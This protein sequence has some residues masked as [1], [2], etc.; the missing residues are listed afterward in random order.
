MQL[1]KGSWKSMTLST[2][3]ILAHE[4]DPAFALRAG[5]ILDAV[6]KHKPERILDAGCGRGFYI[7]MLS[8]YDFPEQIHGVDIS[9]TYL[10]RARKALK[11]DSRVTFIKT[12]V[13]NLPFPDKHFDMI[14]LSE[15][16]KKTNSAT[17]KGQRERQL[18]ETQG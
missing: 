13:Y 18:E 9:K 10:E 7:T 2:S 15:R 1:P 5:K 4:I 14:I 11:H 17:T 6:E 3:D 12:S 8:R 16:R